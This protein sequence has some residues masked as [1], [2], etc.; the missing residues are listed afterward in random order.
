MRE[1]LGA[2]FG[3]E[4]EVQQVVSRLDEVRAGGADLLL[5]EGEPGIGKSALLEAVSSLGVAR[6]FQVVSAGAEELKGHVA[7]G[8]WRDCFGSEISLVVE[9]LSVAFEGKGLLRSS[10]GP[11]EAEIVVTER[12]IEMVEERVSR[13]PLLLVFEDLHWADSSSIYVL[14]RLQH[15]ASS[16]PLMTLCTARPLPR[17]AEL[18]RFASQ[19][20]GEGIMKLGPLDT[21]GVEELAA[22]HLG[23]SL[24]P[25]LRGQLQMTGGNPLFVLEMIE[26][27][28]SEGSL[29]EVTADAVNRSAYEGTV[30]VDSG[31]IAAPPSLLVTILRRLSVF[32]QETLSMLGL[33]SVLGMRFRPARLADLAKA[34][35]AEVAKVLAEAKRSGL[36]L[37]QGEDMVFTHE[38]VR[39]ALYFDLAAPVRVALHREAAR[40]LLASQA[41]AGIIAEHLLRGAEMG[42]EEAAGQ[43]AG[44]ARSLME[45]SPADAV[46]LLTKAVELCRPASPLLVGIRAELAIALLSAGDWKAG[47]A[48]CREALTHGADAQHR[49]DLRRGLVE[50]LLQR[51]LVDE[52]VSEVSAFSD[53]LDPAARASLLGVAAMAEVFRGRLDEAR[54][55][56]DE[57]TRVAGFSGTPAFEVQALVT[58]SLIAE[59]AGEVL[60][61]LRLATQAVARAESA[62]SRGDHIPMPHNALAMFLVD[63]DR[64]TEAISVVARGIEIHESLGNLSAIPILHVIGGFARFWSGDW[65]LAEVDLDTGL[66]LASEMGTGWTAAARGLRSII[67]LGRLE[68]ERARDEIILAGKAL[69]AGEV[70]YRLE[71]LTLGHALLLASDP[72][73]SVT[74]DQLGSLNLADILS[75]GAA[76]A[77]SAA[78][79]VLTRVSL[80]DGQRD[81][82]TQ[83]TGLACRLAERNPTIPGIVACARACQGVISSDPVALAACV[84]DY[85]KA[86]RPV[87][88][89]FVAEE[90]AVAFAAAGRRSEAGTYLEDAL[91]AWRAL[92]APGLASMASRRLALVG[93]H[94]KSP[95]HQP[96]ATHGW[97]S[98]TP[99]ELTVLR[100][101]AERRTN[102]EIAGV[103]NISRRT[104]E[105]HVSHIL[106]K[107]GLVSRIELADG[108][109]Q[110]FGWH[111]RLE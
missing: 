106:D 84:G 92:K 85:R 109:R 54:A 5:I 91:E 111:L 103:L 49:A 63:A 67:A 78:A 96:K 1:E 25:N 74:L 60:E 41:P 6:G 50:S 33:A 43:L 36:L 51:G 72:S 77:M 73:T 79:P 47:E 57:V 105:T 104:V 3:R 2:L 62:G 87:E 56:A 66:A 12:V 11:S 86:G 18:G 19:L 24:G 102:R 94:A 16:W 65:D 45:L 69:A 9:S 59:R 101:L 70:G 90:A 42:D 108:A 4:P 32:S 48:T 80:S 22:F 52:V 100:L 15:H 44:A 107:T 13:S 64:F 110:H 89:A 98:L 35:P 55:M 88:A 97:G 30:V 53:E 68:M 34:H 76:V 83:L 46:V 26:T 39:E 95:L 37:E 81:L 75:G 71:W 61:A 27:L 7:F 58:R 10:S 23:A 31:Q 93:V 99:A 17:P 21:A 14:R 20:G 28:R 38:L 29:R 8:L 82:A 40:V